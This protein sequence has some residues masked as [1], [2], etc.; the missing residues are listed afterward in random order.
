MG[1]PTHPWACRPMTAAGVRPNDVPSPGRCRPL[2][3]VLEL[4]ALRRCCAR[5]ET[6]GSLTTKQR[7]K[8]QHAL[9]WS[10]R[11][12]E[13]SVRAM[14]ICVAS[15]APKP[16]AEDPVL[17][18]TTFECDDSSL[19]RGDEPSGSIKLSME[20]LILAQDERWRRA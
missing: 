5:M 2:R 4:S 14:Q 11:S 13:R 1:R 3:A 10:D 18:A 12:A 15:R 17:D 16:G 6:P 20:S 9:G 7:V 8:S 19:E